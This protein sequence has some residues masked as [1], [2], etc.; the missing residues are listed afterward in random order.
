MDSLNRKG[1]FEI[2]A[3]SKQYFP[4]SIR[5]FFDPALYQSNLTE[6]LLSRSIPWNSERRPDFRYAAC[7]QRYIPQSPSMSD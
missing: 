6:K 1:V 3:L 5:K 4:E 2:E 7:G